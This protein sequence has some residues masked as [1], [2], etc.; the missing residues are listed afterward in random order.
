MTLY[1]LKKKNSTK[2]FIMTL[3]KKNLKGMLSDVIW[4][5]KI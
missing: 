2:T 4:I 5:R 1:E 3:D